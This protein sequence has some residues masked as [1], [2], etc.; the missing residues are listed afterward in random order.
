M[1]SGLRGIINICSVHNCKMQM[2][3]I[4]IL[5]GL[6]TSPVYGYD[7][8][9]TFFPNCDY[10]LLGGCCIVAD[11]SQELKYI[12]EL[13][14]KDREEWKTKHSSEIFF[15]LHYIIS[16]NVIMYLNDDICF[17]IKKEN[18]HNDYWVGIIAIPNDFYKIVA[19]SK[20]TGIILAELEVSLNNEHLDLYFEINKMDNNYYFKI[21]YIDKMDVIS[22]AGTFSRRSASE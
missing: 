1:Q 6:P 17:P 9:E 22:W 2:K 4:D 8:L 3:N 12:C 11:E 15:H 10:I 20:T 7:A 19:K 5:Y 21:A 13:C 14:N 16:E 18:Y